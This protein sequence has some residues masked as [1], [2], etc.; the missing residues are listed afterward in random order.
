M[1]GPR[2]CRETTYP[3][4]FS[5]RPLGNDFL[6]QQTLLVG[7]NS[8]MANGCAKG[9]GG[10]KGRGGHWGIGAT[11]TGSAKSRRRPTHRRD[12]SR[13]PDS[14]VFPHPPAKCAQAKGTH[15]V[16][17]AIGPPSIPRASLDPPRAPMPPSGAMRTR[18][19]TDF[20][21]EADGGRRSWRFAEALI[22]A[23]FP[24][25]LSIASPFF[26]LSFPSHY[27]EQTNPNPTAKSSHQTKPTP[28]NQPPPDFLGSSLVILSR[29]VGAGGLGSS[30]ARRNGGRL[31]S[32]C[33]RV[34][35]FRT[36]LPRHQ[37]QK[38]KSFCCVDNLMST[39][40][41]DVCPGSPFVPVHCRSVIVG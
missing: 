36:L 34:L 41:R 24:A 27:R 20:V 23:P 22:L 15:G 39:D 6:L 35:V 4:T 18:G 1:F 29:R 11:T 14:S 19:G 25:V 7:A 16:G 17:H 30:R 38:K 33:A 5:H 40:L 21:R 10:G 31:L 28:T 3:T 9:R 37:K 26:L 8:A 12:L 32:S 13:L 2:Q